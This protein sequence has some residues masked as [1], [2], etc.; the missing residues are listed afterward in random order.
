MASFPVTGYFTFKASF[1]VLLILSAM[2]LVSTSTGAEGIGLKQKEMFRL[3]NTQQEFFTEIISVFQENK[4]DIQQMVTN[5]QNHLKKNA[6]EK[7][8]E[9]QLKQ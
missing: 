4:A 3:A 5:A 8:I 2:P 1:F 7:V 6:P 9:E